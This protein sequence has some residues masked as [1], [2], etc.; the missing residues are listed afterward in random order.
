MTVYET[1]LIIATV[2]IEDG[3]FHP[4]AY[5]EGNAAIGRRNRCISAAIHKLLEL[6]E[7]V[8]S[9]KKQLEREFAYRATADDCQLFTRGFCTLTCNEGVAVAVGLRNGRRVVLAISTF[10][11]L[12]WEGVNEEA[13][14]HAARRAHQEQRHLM[15]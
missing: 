4:A 13:E 6:W 14:L 3:A 1:N 12:S 8:L 7:E 11:D 2:A 9:N 15:R 10:D 5:A